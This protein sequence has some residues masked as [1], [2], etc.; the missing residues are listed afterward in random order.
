MKLKQILS[1][2]LIAAMIFSITACG[3]TDTKVTD[4]T[5]AKT[6][7]A[8]EE[9]I[10]ETPNEDFVVVIDKENT[11]AVDAAERM[12]WQ[13]KE[14][15]GIDIE[16]IDHKEKAYVKEIVL[17]KTNRGEKIDTSKMVVDDYEIKSVG[18][19]I[20]I[21]GASDDG[22][23]GGAVKLLNTCTDEGGFNVAKDYSFVNSEGYPIDKLTINGNDIS[24]YKIVYPEGASDNT[25]I[26]A[27]DL[28]EYIEKAC[29]VKL[30]IT[31]ESFEYAIIVDET[32]I[33]VE[34][35]F[36]DNVE[37]F[38]VKSEGNSI[39][40]SGDAARGTMY[41]CYDFLE[42]V[43]GWIFL[44]ETQDYLSPVDELDISGLDYTEGSAYEH[45]WTSWKSYEPSIDMQNKHR[46]WF[47]PWVGSSS[48][49]F[50]ALAPGYST[51]FESQPCLTDEKVYELMFENVLKLL[52]SYPTAK[53]VSVS[54]NDNEFYC[55]CENC[56]AIAE[57]EGSQ[58]GPLSV[59]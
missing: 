29:G 21:D 38:S 14:K 11:G 5:T 23:Y 35:S 2:I 42:D 44:T 41:G 50:E 40:I 6:E 53:L 27:N 51:Q 52:E 1:L 20:F 24:K 30:E 28:V 25:M 49:T 19:K 7:A 58:S 26:V 15:Y 33:V 12:T 31:T 10:P 37:N 55:T 59:L 45:R 13:M 3:K 32:T 9:K 47:I 43:V 18:E 57:E 54:Q 8:T 22:L 39:R 34:G 17:G 56:S 4:G 36:N 48:H 46:L 16:V